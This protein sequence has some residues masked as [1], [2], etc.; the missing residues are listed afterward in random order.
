M[1]KDF[2]G[3]CAFRDLADS[4]SVL[5]RSCL[6]RRKR[7]LAALLILNFVDESLARPK[8]ACGPVH[9]G[10]S[11]VALR[12]RKLVGPPDQHYARTSGGAELRGNPA[13]IQALTPPIMSVARHSPTDLK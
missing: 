4:R 11:P 2:K 3:T 7:G 8:P 10:C 9:C 12:Q 6:V 13:S 1:L 5:V